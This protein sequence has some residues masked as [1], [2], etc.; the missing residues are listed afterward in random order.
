MSD[1]SHAEQP[2]AGATPHLA[3]DD[4]YYVKIWAIL[5]GLLVVSIIGPEL[6]IKVVTMITAFGIAVVKAY[7]VATRFMHIN[8]EKK[9]IPY[10]LGTMLAIMALMIGAMS[11]DVMKH[12][13]ARWENTAAKES[14]KRGMLLHPG[15]HGADHAKPGDHDASAAQKMGADQKAADDQKAAAEKH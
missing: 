15:A 2:A 8:S 13:G 1:H 9:I 14:V 12:E 3:H 4:K 5:C 6:G 10:M 7:L 11:P